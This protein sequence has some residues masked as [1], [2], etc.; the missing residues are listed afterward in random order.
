M[1]AISSIIH[2]KIVPPRPQSFMVGIL[3]TLYVIVFFF[4]LEGNGLLANG[5]FIGRIDNYQFFAL[6]GLAFLLGISLLSIAYFGYRTTTQW[7]WLLIALL[8]ATGNTVAV[9]MNCNDVIYEGNVVFTFDIAYKAR[10]IILGFLNA[11]TFF[12]AYS[13]LP[14]IIGGTMWIRYV[15]RIIVF[16]AILSI[17]GSLV[18]ENEAWKLFFTE[19]KM[20]QDIGSFYG[21]KNIFGFVLFVAFLSEFLVLAR[22]P[23]WWRWLIVVFLALMQIPLM[24][25]T[26]SII[27]FFMMIVMPIMCFARSFK[28]HKV[29][30][31]LILAGIL[32]VL[33]GIVVY[34]MIPDENGSAPLLNIFKDI[35]ASIINTGFDTVGA[36]WEWTLKA[37]DTVNSF[38]PIGMFFGL[39]VKSSLM[40]FFGANYGS[41]FHGLPTD[42]DWI[43]S[44]LSNGILGLSLNVTVWIAVLVVILKAMARGC[45]ES[46]VSLG[47]YVAVLART[48][49]EMGGLLIFDSATLGFYAV[50]ALVPLTYNHLHKHPE[51]EEAV[52][53]DYS[54]YKT[55]AIVDGPRTNYAL[56]RSLFF[57][58]LPVVFGIWLTSEFVGISTPRGMACVFC[59]AIYAIFAPAVFGSY[60]QKFSLF[61]RLFA[62]L[63]GT[64]LLAFAYVVPFFVDPGIAVILSLVLAVLFIAIPFLFK[65]NVPIP[66]LVKNYAPYLFV[67]IGSLV[68]AF[69]VR[70]V[71]PEDGFY[72]LTSS[73]FAVVLWSLVYV[74]RPA[75]MVDSGFDDYFMAIEHAFDR[76]N[77]IAEAKMDDL[78]ER[79]V[80]R[81]KKQLAKK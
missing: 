48:F 11:L 59:M 56:K 43:Y 13:V 17:A 8:L 78:Y 49:F 34:F 64:I 25:R 6:S 37:F 40:V 33:A 10:F 63:G 70:I 47:I 19:G 76:H 74:L 41:V 71:I 51:I 67:V 55:H 24:S 31:L 58:A 4:L 62:L 3:G 57:S 44:Y 60:D 26:H 73:L 35:F 16:I 18:M 12:L 20:N 14:R 32:L 39:G 36:R 7:G 79:K 54:T 69:G 30:N 45:K 52:M 75:K 38:G 65:S 29:R 1:A 28:A 15:L 66:T 72:V 46:T 53:A 81:N 2:R 21:N 27:V 68:F 80:L 50:V 77:L 42:N 9:V 22:T 23:R 61:S 5:A